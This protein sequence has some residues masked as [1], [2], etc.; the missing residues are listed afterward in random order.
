MRVI[1]FPC[2]LTGVETF[3]SRARAALWEDFQASVSS[4]SKAPDNA[5]TALKLPAM[6]KIEKRHRFAGEDVV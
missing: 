6:V 2:C 3:T 1:T 4:S 5:E